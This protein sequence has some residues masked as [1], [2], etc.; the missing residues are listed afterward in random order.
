MKAIAAQDR[1]E[2][3]WHQRKDHLA[4]NIVQQAGCPQQPDVVRKWQVAL[5]VACFLGHIG[6]LSHVSPARSSECHRYLHAYAGMA[7]GEREHLADLE[8]VTAIGL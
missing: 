6:L 2:K 8:T 3:L 7:P 4:G 5:I 1:N